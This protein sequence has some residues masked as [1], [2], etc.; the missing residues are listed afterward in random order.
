[1]KGMIVGEEMMMEGRKGSNNMSKKGKI[2]LEMKNKAKTQTKHEIETT[3]NL[4]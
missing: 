1:M 3:T 2:Q 4:Y